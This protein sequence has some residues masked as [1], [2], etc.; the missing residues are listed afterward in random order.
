MATNLDDSWDEE[1]I[2][3][4]EQDANVLDLDRR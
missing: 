1:Q 4:I 3:M 2:S